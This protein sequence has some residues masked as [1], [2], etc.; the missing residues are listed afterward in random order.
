MTWHDIGNRRSKVKVTAQK[1]GGRGVWSL[2]AC[3]DS[4]S[5]MLSICK[6]SI[7]CTALAPLVG[8]QEVHPACKELDVG[9][10]IAGL[11]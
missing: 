5:L 1:A 8:R 3:L 6:I 7:Q 10:F 9:L 11:I 4:L 2:H